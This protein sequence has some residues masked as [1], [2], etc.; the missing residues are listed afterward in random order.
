MYRLQI[1]IL[2]L[3]FISGSANAQIAEDNYLLHTPIPQRLF[4]DL[5]IWDGMLHE[6]R[7]QRPGETPAIRA[8]VVVVHLW[9]DYCAP[10]REEFPILRDFAERV[11][12]T[13]PG[14]VEF[15]FLS[16]TGSPLEMDR[17]LRAERARMP[18]APL[19]FDRAGTVAALLS[20]S[21]PSGKQSLPITVVLDSARIVRQAVI[22]PIAG[23]RS[24]L[25]AGIAKLLRLTQPLTSN[26]K[27]R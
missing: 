16:E 4:S 1:G 13:H 26:A 6:W 23:S 24:V 27:A 25:A 15:V 22:G 2:V 12:R 10:C 3:F 17:F 20:D 11:E 7:Q 21:R 8:P 9:A 14:Q 18:R 5:P 19:Y